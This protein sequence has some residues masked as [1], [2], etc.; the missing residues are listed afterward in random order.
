MEMQI[1][2]MVKNI[3]KLYSKIYNFNDKTYYFN[4]VS[5]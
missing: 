2:E 5:C 3:N 4:F 1:R